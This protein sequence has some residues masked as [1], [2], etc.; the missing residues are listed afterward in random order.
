MAGVLYGWLFWRRHLEAAMACHA[1][2]HL[3]FAAWRILVT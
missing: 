3:G 1:A 2:T